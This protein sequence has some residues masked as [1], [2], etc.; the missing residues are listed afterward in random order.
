[1]TLYRDVAKAGDTSNLALLL[2]VAVLFQPIVEEI[3]FRGYFKR[4]FKALGQ[5][6]IIGIVAS[7]II[8]GLAHAYQG[9][10]MMFVIGV[11]GMFFGILAHFR[12]SLRPGMM[13]HAFHDTFTGMMLRFLMK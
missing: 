13:A 7:A 10:R 12:K 3:I 4:Q 6:A 1:M 2:F 9:K 8:F 11:Y 5:N